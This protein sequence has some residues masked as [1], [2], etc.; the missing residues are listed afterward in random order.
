[1]LVWGDYLLWYDFHGTSQGI[2]ILIVHQLLHTSAITPRKK[3]YH[4]EK[5][6]EYLIL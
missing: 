6:L 5:Y 1:M 3:I 2:K 4:L